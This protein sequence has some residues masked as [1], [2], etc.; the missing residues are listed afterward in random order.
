[1]GQGIRHIELLSRSG[2]LDAATASGNP[3]L[4]GLLQGGR[5]W[6]AAVTITRCDAAVDEE[7]RAVLT[8][9]RGGRLLCSRCCCCLQTLAVPTPDTRGSQPE[10]LPAK[11]QVATSAL[12]SELICLVFLVQCQSCRGSCMREAC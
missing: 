2:K 11:I 4:A 7:V 8:G 12:S 1:M 6:A 5:G 3:H 10:I 9:R